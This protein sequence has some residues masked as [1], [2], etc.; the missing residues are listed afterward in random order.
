MSVRTRSVDDRLVS[1]GRND[2]VGRVADECLVRK[3]RLLNTRGHTKP[4]ENTGV[5]VNHALPFVTAETRIQFEREH[6]V[7]VEPEVDLLQL[8]DR[9][10]EEQSCDD[11]C[12]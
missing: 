10:H 8:P 12:H 4:L 9:A 7:R 11:E 2:D 3:R 1:A 6:P 5:D